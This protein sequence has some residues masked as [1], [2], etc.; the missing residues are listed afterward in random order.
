MTLLQNLNQKQIDAVKHND[1]PLLILAGAGSGK[2]RTLIHKIA[3]LIQE[4]KVSPKQ[5]LAMTFT[6]KAASEMKERIGKQVGRPA[7]DIWMGTFHSICARILRTNIHF[8]GYKKSFV[9]LDESDQ[10]NIMKKCLRE[11]NI[12]ERVVKAGTAQHMIND[13][14]NKSLYFHEEKINDFDFTRKKVAEISKYYQDKLKENNVVDFGDLQV[15]VVKLFKEKKEVLDFYRER[16]SHVLVDEYQDTNYVQYLLLKL[17]GDQKSGLTV[18]GD[19]D[20]SIYRWRGACLDNILHFK[21]E[22]KGT[23]TIRLEQNYR[24]T[25]LILDAAWHVVNKNLERLGKKLWTQNEKGSPITVY[26]ALNEKHEATLCLKNIVKIRMD[27]PNTR[28]SDFAI[29]YRTNAQSRVFEEELIRNNIPYN[30]IGGYKFYERMEI[31]DILSYLRVLV[32]PDDSFSLNRIINVPN[33]GIGEK[34]KTD[35]QILAKDKNVSLFKAIEIYLK[36]N[37]KKAAAKKIKNFLDLFNLLKKESKTLDPLKLTTLILKK[38]NYE[39]KLK[40]DGTLEAESRL[41]NLGELLNAVED[42]FKIFPNHSLTD[43]LEKTSLVSHVDQLDDQKNKLTLMTLHCAK[44]LEYDNVF[45][46]GMEEGLFP[47]SLSMDSKAEFEE[48][49]RLCYVGMTRAKKRLFLSLAQTRRLKGHLTYNIP[50][51][52]LNEIPKEL[53]NVLPFKADYKYDDNCQFD[54]RY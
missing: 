5:I 34:T 54:Q 19:D 39:Q 18:V 47:H 45:M 23:K 12:N 1:S 41:E 20:Q 33:R 3:Y 50:S 21:D 24:S 13:A 4:L 51:C 30:L 40:E 53:T 29:F 9:I 10:Q 49:R 15:L 43:F 31:K 25:K 44:G 22:F 36:E 26:M 48:E 16:W 8:L 27:N 17:L 46:V 35:L 28:L 14:K 11:L 32:N 42:Y 2:T 38:T 52:F 6:N 37:S 7:H